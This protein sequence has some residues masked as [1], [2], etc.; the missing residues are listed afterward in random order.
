M[1]PLKLEITILLDKTQYEA[2]IETINDYI[3]KSVRN[4]VNRMLKR[5]DYTIVSKR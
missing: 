4:E 3:A 5:K 1:Y 2:L